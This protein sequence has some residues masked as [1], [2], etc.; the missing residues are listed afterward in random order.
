MFAK[1]T[2]KAN[3]FTGEGC[4]GNIEK[5]RELDSLIRLDLLRDWIYELTNEYESASKELFYKVNQ[6]APF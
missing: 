3:F 2:L 4:I 1:P 6:D 5:F